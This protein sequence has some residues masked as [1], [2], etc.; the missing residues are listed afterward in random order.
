MK[1]SYGMIITLT[2]VLA[3]FAGSPAFAQDEGLE[4]KWVLTKRKLPDGTIL[5]PPQVQGQFSV[6]RGLNQLVVFWPMSN[7]SSA[8]LSSISKWEWSESEVAVTPF[9]MIF[10]DGSGKPPA[11]SVGGDTKRSPVTRNGGVVSYQHPTD[12]PFNVWDG[13]H[14]TATFEGVFVDYWERVR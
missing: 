7:G 6:H 5:R 3:V 8:S 13:D 11:Y 4:G 12:P 14:L 1:I 10:D 9:L 2:V